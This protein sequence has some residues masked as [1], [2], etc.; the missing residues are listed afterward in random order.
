MATTIRW[1]QSKRAATVE[2]VG[3]GKHTIEEIGGRLE[4][5]QADSPRSAAKKA[6][7]PA[8]KR[9]LVD[10]IAEEFFV[11]ERRACR[12]VKLNRSTCRYQSHPSD[13][14]ALRMRVKELA[15][16]RPR[17]G[18]RRIFILLRREGW[19]VNH[20]RVYRIYKEEGLMVRTKR[21]RKHAAKTRL[22]PLPVTRRAEH[23]SVDFVADQLTDG[24]RFRAFTSIDHF[25]RESVCIKVGKSLTS[26]DV[27]RALDEAI[28]QFGQP[29]IITLDNGTEFTCKHF[30][31]WAYHRGIKLDFISPGRPVE[32]AFIESF[33]G[34]L[35]D[36]CL[37]VHWF[38][39]IWEAQFLIEK[40]RREYN[41]MR[42]HSSLGNLAPREY[43]AHLLRTT[44]WGAGHQGGR[45]CQRRNI[46][47]KTSSTSLEKQMCCKPKGRQ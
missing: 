7:K 6:V 12:L 13:D 22:K 44:L 21:R 42:P 33:N 36:K 31:S 41:E 35:R 32:N 8:R 29:E 47:Q 27:T 26:K 46:A 18:Y 1:T 16:S 5:G 20:K 19:P 45:V 43:V 38:K 23:W 28:T 25:S 30:D 4:S 2:G 15:F 10:E 37:N 17:Y 40:W 39:D 34:K 9:K 24:R 3:A 14:R 11:S